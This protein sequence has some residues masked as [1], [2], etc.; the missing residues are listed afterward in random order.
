MLACAPE[1]CRPK[2]HK[3]QTAA[4]VL[5]ATADKYPPFE[6]ALSLA[7]DLGL[8]TQTEWRAWCKGAKNAPLPNCP[9]R[10]YRGSGWQGYAHWLM[11]PPLGKRAHA[12][13]S[14]RH[15]PNKLPKLMPPPATPDTLYVCGL[16]SR[17]S[18]PR[19]AT[20]RTNTVGDGTGEDA[21]KATVEQCARDL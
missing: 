1:P 16:C 6:E 8:S 14:E 10:V 12:G 18:S 15:T 17:K 5:P 21:L 9:D 3:R 13:G 2:R 20:H 7:R 11:S 19:P 4:A